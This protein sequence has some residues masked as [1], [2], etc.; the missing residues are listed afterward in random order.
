MLRFATILLTV[1]LCLRGQGPSFDA[2]S[3]KPAAMD[4][5]ERSLTHNAGGRLS[6]R[7]ATVLMLVYLAYQVMPY[8]VSGGPAWVDSDGFD[9]EAKAA[10]PNATPEQFR[11]M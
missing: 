7:N 4:A 9:I 2:A 3:V 6:A 5:T 8:Q 1:G 11:Q 10:N